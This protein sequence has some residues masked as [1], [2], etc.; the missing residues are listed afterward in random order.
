[1]KTK[2]LWILTAGIVGGIAISSAWNVWAGHEKRDHEQPAKMTSEPSAKAAV[3]LDDAAVRMGGIVAAP[4]QPVSHRQAIQALAV[5]LSSLE[6]NDL[7]NAHAAAK[8]QVEA[9]QATAEA[10]GKEYA[11][12]KALNANDR[13]VSDKALQ[14]A[15]ALF[16]S[17]KAR[18]KTSVEALRTVEQKVRQQWGPRLA[19]AIVNN[20][21]LFRRLAAQQDVLVQITL[22]GVYLSSP[23]PTIRLQSP[24][25]GFAEAT[26]I[27][28]APRTDPRFQGQSFFYS[29][30]VQNTGLVPG[31]NLSAYLPTGPEEQG[32][33]VPEASVVWSQGKAW[34]Y[35]E[36]SKGHY[37]KRELPASG[38]VTDGWFVPEQFTEGKLAVV[39]GA[40]LLLSDELRPTSSS[41]GEEDND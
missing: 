35:L 6:L 2:S 33:L 38:S 17:D 18:Q 39:T 23:P 20:T 1:M 27:S 26:L 28:L 4:L 3:T 19:D 30:S 21:L 32:Y 31:M 8:A 41:G 11:R 37:V 5:V 15:E 14:T 9:A 10:S 12:L 36:E 34:V 13:N 24:G 16:R 7:H 22:S 25:D 40:E 29:A